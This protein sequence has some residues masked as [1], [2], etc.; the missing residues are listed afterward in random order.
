MPENSA[1]ASALSPSPGSSALQP[2]SSRFCK[3][4]PKGK[5]KVLPEATSLDAPPASPVPA[6]PSSAS[7]DKGKAPVEDLN[8]VTLADAPASEA[9]HRVRRTAILLLPVALA[10][11]VASVIT[12]VRTLMKRVW[13]SALS[14]GAF[15][16]AK[17]Q[18]LLPAYVAKTRYCRLQVSLLRKDDIMSVRT[19]EVDYTRPNGMVFRLYWQHTDDPS[20]VRERATNPQA[21]EVVIRDVPATKTPEMLRELMVVYQLR[22]RKLSAF[23]DGIC[24]HRV[25]HPVTGAD[26]DVIK[27]LVIP[28]PGDRHRWPA[29]LPASPLITPILLDPAIVLISTGGNCEEWLCTQVGCGKAKGRS[30]MTAADHITSANHL[31]H[32]E[33]LGSATRVSL[34]KASL[35]ITKKDYGI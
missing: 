9:F 35:N 1:M 14:D 20:F 11:E 17:F 16:S 8:N 5:S 26:T 22:N 2:F 28:H 33:Q 7:K 24:F 10:L 30:F 32:L 3:M 34:E 19:K 12:T 27:G 13:A 29:S 18:E 15:E 25:L 4:P 21:I 6:A 31:I 23:K